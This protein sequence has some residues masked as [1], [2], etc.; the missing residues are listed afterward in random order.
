MKKTKQVRLEDE[1]IE[2]LEGD[3]KRKGHTLS[4]LLRHI[5]KLYIKKL[6]GMK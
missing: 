2:I 4:S 3:A 6:R 5:V 1:D